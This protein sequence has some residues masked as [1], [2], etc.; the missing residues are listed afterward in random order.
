MKLTRFE[1]LD[2]WQEARKLVNKVYTVTKDGKFKKDLR[3]S[4]QIQA[5]SASIMANIAEGFIRRSNKEFNQFLY[6]AMSS[7]AE[8]QSHLYIALDQGYIDQKQFGA[9][10]DQ[11]N[12]TAKIISGLIK[13]LRTKTR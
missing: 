3:L 7:A 9:I 2:C 10:Y 6:I 13:Y 5:A 8:V 4:G 11:A 12:K 1:D